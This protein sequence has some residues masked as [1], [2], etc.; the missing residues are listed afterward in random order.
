MKNVNEFSSAALNGNFAFLIQD[1]Q[2]QESKSLAYNHAQFI[3]YTA[4]QIA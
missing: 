2:S 1:N 4:N 3:C